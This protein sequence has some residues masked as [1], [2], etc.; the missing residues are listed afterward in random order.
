MRSAALLFLLAAAASAQSVTYFHV[1]GAVWGIAAGSDGNLWY[2]T[3]AGVAKMTVDGSVTVYPTPAPISSGRAMIAAGPDGRMWF[4]EPNEHRIG[5]VTT[6]GTV[7][8]YALASDVVPMGIA[9]GADG[10]VWF[11]TNNAVGKITPG[12]RVTLFPL[13]FHGQVFGLVA[14]GDG[15]IWFIEWPQNVFGFV[16]PAGVILELS[17]VVCCGPQSIARA[18][19]G[20]LWLAL[21]HAFMRV[22]PDGP[23]AVARTTTDFVTAVTTGPDG[24]I[25]YATEGPRLGTVDGIVVDLA[26]E[27]P[28]VHDIA[29]GPDGNVWATLDLPPTNCTIVCPA[30]DLN[31]PPA[32]VRVNLHPA[33]RR[34]AVHTE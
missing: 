3:A 17:T 26:P 31:P 34:R 7:V 27:V 19:D 23:M 11:G 18:G 16:T 4:T 15:N 2:P 20:A 21:D 14:G 5:A 32:I 13:E 6:G 12:G 30:P 24:K 28:R 29:A 9:A 1:A 8:E 25:W 10:N 33:P 22:P